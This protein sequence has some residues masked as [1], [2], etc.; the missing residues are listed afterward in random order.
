MYVHYEK[1]G[2]NCK[3]MKE[4]CMYKRLRVCIVIIAYTYYA[5]PARLKKVFKCKHGQRKAILTRDN[6]SAVTDTWL[7]PLT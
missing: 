1:N 3:Q 2:A 5:Y 6:S 4:H 7:I